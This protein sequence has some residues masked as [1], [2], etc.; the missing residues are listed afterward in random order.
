VI[1]MIPLW[2][3]F[4]IHFFICGPIT[5][6]VGSKKLKFHLAATAGGKGEKTKGWETQPHLYRWRLFRAKQQLCS[7]ISNHRVQDT[8]ANSV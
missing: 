7:F 6:W 1:E 3:F 4:Q 5:L 2:N 8:A